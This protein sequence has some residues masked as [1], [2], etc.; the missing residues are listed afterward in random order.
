MASQS[1]DKSS[2]PV[3]RDSELLPALLAIVLAVAAQL[4]LNDGL[5][6]LGLAG[7]F[8]AAWL[9]VSNVQATFDSVSQKT[10]ERDR[11]PDGAQAAVEGEAAAMAA[12]PG[13]A[14]SG[15]DKLGYLRRHWR[16]VTLAEIF[17]GDIPPIRLREQADEAVDDAASNRLRVISLS[18]ADSTGEE[19]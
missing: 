17:V 11:L 15:A 10:A 14:T 9:F 5:T 12:P 7:Y 6:L 16:Q 18:D 1:E 4:A 2:P 19:E 8:V 3:A 13:E